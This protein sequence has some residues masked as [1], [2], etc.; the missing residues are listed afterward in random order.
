MKLLAESREGI[1]QCRRVEDLFCGGP[2]TPKPV[3]D[4]LA[5][6]GVGLVTHFC[7][8]E[9]GQLMNSLRRLSEIEEWN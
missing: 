3:G 5:G 1:E 8:T 4:K 6:A 2:P 7:S 9:T